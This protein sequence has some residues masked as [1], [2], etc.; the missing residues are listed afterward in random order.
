MLEK[1]LKEVT[2]KELVVKVQLAREIQSLQEE[3]LKIENNIRGICYNTEI[4]F[5]FVRRY[6]FKQSVIQSIYVGTVF[7]YNNLFFHLLIKYVFYESSFLLSH[8]YSMKKYRNN[9]KNQV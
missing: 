7:L 1:L 5:R 9:E 2:E 3:K 6:K 4:I 8:I